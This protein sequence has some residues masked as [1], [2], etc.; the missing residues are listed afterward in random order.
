MHMYPDLKVSVRGTATV[1]V[2]PAIGHA[3]EWS[4]C[5]SYYDKQQNGEA[6]NRSLRNLLHA[7]HM[8]KC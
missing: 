3:A 8:P 7:E 1:V 5:S 6:D 4:N 2:S